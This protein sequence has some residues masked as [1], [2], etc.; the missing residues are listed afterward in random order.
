MFNF[1]TSL[2]FFVFCSIPTKVPV[3]WVD[4]PILEYQE[5][6]WQE[7]EKYPVNTYSTVFVVSTKFVGI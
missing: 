7:V 1:S 2:V 5:T 3:H 4:V 6:A